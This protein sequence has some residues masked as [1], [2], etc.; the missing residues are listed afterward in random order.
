MHSPIV[1]MLWENWRLT[2]IEVAQR[3]GLGLLG[4][5]AAL[6]LMDDGAVVA[7]GVLFALHAFFYMSIAKLNGGRFMDGYKPGFPLYLL[8]TR[9]VRT[10]V[11]VGVAMLYDAVT[12]TAFFLLAAALLS[13]A[14]GQPLPLFSVALCLVA[15]HFVFLCIQWSNRSRVAQWIGSMVVTIP[16]FLLIKS[17]VT[18]PLQ[19]E[20]SLVEM[21]LMVVICIVAFGLTVAGVARQRRGGADA[22]VTRK[23]VTGEYPD[24]LVNLFRFPCPTSSARRAQL[25][26]ELKSSGLPVMTMGAALALLIFLLFVISIPVPVVRPIAMSC[27]MFAPPVMLLFLGGNAFGIRRR[28]GRTYLS[29]FEATQPYGTTQIAGLKVLVRTACLLIALIV[30][31]VSAWTSSALASVWGPWMMNGKDSIAGWL[32]FR[33]EIGNE[34]LWGLTAY[35]YVVQAVLV[36]LSIVLMVALLAAFMALQA[37]YARRLLIGFSVLLFYALGIVAL[38]VAKDQ[39]LVSMSVLHAVLNATGW[40]AAAAMV[41]AIVYTFWSGFAERALTTGYVCGSVV[42]SAA[43]AA[44]S[45]PA[46]SVASVAA[47]MLLPLMICLLVPWSLSR[48]RHM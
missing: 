2:R 36:L 17:R 6:L 35:E 15:C 37:R 12:S 9:P 13:F 42:I 48:V 39:G 10:S 11:F 23:A 1:A 18:W 34:F 4:G 22:T 14:F 25:W 21:A 3:L 27:A 41:F 46:N 31:S 43:F 40:I 30:I 19:V 16:A 24:W 26:F 44:A 7:F 38:A 32:K 8:Y 20:F 29:A 45:L 5:S 33:S 28:Q 47:T